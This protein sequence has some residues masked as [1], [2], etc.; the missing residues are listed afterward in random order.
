[1]N[2][3][4]LDNQGFIPIERA[5]ENNA[6]R[7]IH[8]LN[9]YS[10]YP[11]VTDY[12]LY[13]KTSVKE[14]NYLPKNLL[15]IITNYESKILLE[16]HEFKIQGKNKFSWRNLKLAYQRNN[17]KLKIGTILYIIYLMFVSLFINCFNESF[18]NPD[19]WNVIFITQ[20]ITKFIIGLFSVIFLNKNEIF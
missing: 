2:F 16:D 15:N 19:L 9:S 13:N 10:H 5:A 17:L 18:E 1:M 7:V 11:F 6:S 14:F 8:F 3:F 4:I 12:F 20:S